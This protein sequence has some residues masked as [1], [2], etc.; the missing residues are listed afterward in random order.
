MTSTFDF[1]WTL[2]DTARL[3]ELKSHLEGDCKDYFSSDLFRFYRLDR[4]MEHPEHEIGCWFAKAKYWGYIEAVGEIPS[5]IE[6]N[7]RRKNDLWKLSGRMPT[8]TLEN[9]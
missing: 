4:F 5:V 2:A 7:H 3:K 6:S 9:Y 8:K 1:T